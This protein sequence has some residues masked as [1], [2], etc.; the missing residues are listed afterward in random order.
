[1]AE[2]EK[3][4]HIDDDWKTE[5]KKDKERLAAQEKVEKQEAEQQKRGPL[6]KGDFIALVSLLATQAMF[7]LG[8][9]QM[10]K[11][12]KEPDLDMAKYN[13]DMLEA[14]EEK[15]KGNLTE[16]EEKGIQNTLSQLQMAYV[17]IAG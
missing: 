16:D 2:E 1:M 13:I 11:E 9:I 5:A 12:K 4:L 14:L 10:E 8:L 3:K 17:K 6:P 7:A 15:T